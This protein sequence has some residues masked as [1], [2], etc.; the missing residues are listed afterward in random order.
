M[1]CISVYRRDRQKESLSF[2][3]HKKQSYLNQTDASLLLQLF[4]GRKRSLSQVGIQF[5]LDCKNYVIMVVPETQSFL[6]LNHKGTIQDS[7]PC[8]SSLSDKRKG[9][10]AQ[11][12]VYLLHLFSMHLMK[13]TPLLGLRRN[14]KLNEKNCRRKITFLGPLKLICG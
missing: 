8:G 14:V 11:R 6:L 9:Y 3:I 7:C 12:A 1:I 2:V 13:P 4:N 5:R 10:Y